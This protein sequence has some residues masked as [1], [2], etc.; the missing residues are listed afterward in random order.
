MYNTGSQIKF[1]TSML[2]SSLCDNSDAYILGRGTITV[3]E[4][5]AGGG[6]NNIQV[7]FKSSAPFTDYINEI[8]NVKTDNAKDI[9][10]V[11]PIYNLI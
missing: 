9:N 7:V 6:N 5:A 10:V 11:M 8:N 1:N 3:T 2:R 4:V